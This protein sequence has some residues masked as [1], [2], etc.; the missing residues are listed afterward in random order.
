[1]QDLLDDQQKL[2]SHFSNIMSSFESLSTVL[3]HDLLPNSGK[4]DWTLTQLIRDLVLLDGLK[5]KEEL[6]DYYESHQ[7]NHFQTPIISWVF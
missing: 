5:K 4:V 1:M 6:V 2:V 7:V 3:S